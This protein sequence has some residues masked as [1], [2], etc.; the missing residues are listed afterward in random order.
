MVPQTTEE[1]TSAFGLSIYRILV[2][3]TTGKWPVYCSLNKSI[4]LSSYRYEFS[5]KNYKIRKVSNRTF[6]Y[7][8][9]H[10]V[11]GTQINKK[12]VKNLVIIVWVKV[13]PMEF[14]EQK[15]H[16][17]PS[18]SLVE[19]KKLY[20]I[21][22]ERDKKFDH[23]RNE[24]KSCCISSPNKDEKTSFL[25]KFEPPPTSWGKS[26]FGGGTHL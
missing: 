8:M 3:Y 19:T 17:F 9:W 10:S 22:S 7:I 26:C 25:I 2:L 21:H 5:M 4:F 23:N 20:P 1:V 13:S 15:L 12:R 6:L 18:K 14:L 16:L 24:E 11:F